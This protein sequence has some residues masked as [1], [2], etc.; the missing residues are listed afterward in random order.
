M[1]FT[2]CPQSSSSP[3]TVR[4]TRVTWLLQPAKCCFWAEALRTRGRL[5]TF[6][7]PPSKCPGIFQLIGRGSQ[8]NRKI[9]NGSGVSSK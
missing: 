6:S 4:I 3:H 7:V 1:L 9:C 8:N 2:K 5:I